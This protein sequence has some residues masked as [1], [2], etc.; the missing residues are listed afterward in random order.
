LS[1]RD[2]DDWKSG[3]APGAAF[4][5]APIGIGLAEG[6]LSDVIKPFSTALSFATDSVV[7]QQVDLAPGPK[8]KTEPVL[9]DDVDGIL[10]QR[11]DARPGTT[12]LFRPD[13]HVAARWKQPNS[14]MIANAVAR[15]KGRA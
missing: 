4:A 7:L 2:R 12:Y 9:I 14:S 6:F 8:A 10:A 3:P 11:Y 15:A 5:D 13:G 1:T